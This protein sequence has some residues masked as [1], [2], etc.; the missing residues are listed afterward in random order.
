M[1]V[2]F[3]YDYTVVVM[4]ELVTASDYS[5]EY[6][7]LQYPYHSSISSCYSTLSGR[8]PIDTWEDDRDSIRSRVHREDQLIEHLNE[9]RLIFDFLDVRCG[10]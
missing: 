10:R 6:G 4:A 1:N 3:R 2:V 7:R 9:K 5:L 8:H